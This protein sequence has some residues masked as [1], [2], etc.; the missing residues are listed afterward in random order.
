MFKLTREFFIPKGAIKVADRQSDA[1]AYLYPSTNANGKPAAVVFYG[2]SDKPVSRHYY[3]SEK[4]REQ[5]VT[6]A[7]EGRRITLAEKAKR[8]AER[9]AWVPD[10]KV[11][12]VLHTCWGY[13]QT[14]VEFFEVVEVRGKHLILRELQQERTETGWQQGT[15]RPVPGKYRANEAPIRR[16][17]QQHG[18][19]I[20]DVRTAYRGG[21]ECHWTA[22]H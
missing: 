10:Y 22:Y 8:R 9:T 17:A 1:V 14:N 19:K 16:L 11:G 3:L 21:G 18:V 4:Q 15:C 20:D 2:K 7:F 12:D 5:A 6:R 13:E